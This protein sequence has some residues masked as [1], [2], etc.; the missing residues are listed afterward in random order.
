VQDHVFAR[1]AFFEILT[2][3]PAATDRAE[4]S[5]DTFTTMLAPGF[6]AHPDVP[7]V[8]GEAIIGG[9]WSVIQREVGYGRAKQLPELTA[10]LTYI[11]LTPF[12]GAEQA[13]RV[14]GS[15]R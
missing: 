4:Q 5:L 1:L 8:V 12:L 7:E 9:L 2:G 13:A 6:Q 11:T 3:G 10:E 14:A 15:G